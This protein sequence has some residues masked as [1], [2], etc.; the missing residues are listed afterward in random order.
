MC[1]FGLKEFDNV[2]T[3][4][5]CCRFEFYIGKGAATAFNKKYFGVCVSS[6][7]FTHFFPTSER[8]YSLNAFMIVC[9]LLVDLPSIFK[10]CVLGAE[11]SIWA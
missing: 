9:G 2:F 3:L 11:E 10:T 6:S 5:C 1:I 4:L 7:A 8:K